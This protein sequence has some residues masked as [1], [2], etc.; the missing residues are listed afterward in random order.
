MLGDNGLACCSPCPALCCWLHAACRDS[1]SCTALQHPRGHSSTSAA[2]TG[3]TWD[4]AF[5]GGGGKQR[6]RWGAIR[7][8]G[9]KHIPQQL[10]RKI[11]SS[12][13]LH[14]GRWRGRWGDGAIS[15][16]TPSMPGSLRCPIHTQPP[17]AAAGI[18]LGT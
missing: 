17:A 16:P 15:W 14:S 9:N 2:G 18:T 4:K 8:D 12:H 7:A 6:G 5:I 3:G 1:S 11:A 10:H 13:F